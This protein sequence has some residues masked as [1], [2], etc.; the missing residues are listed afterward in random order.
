[1][2]L[3]TIVLTSA[4]LVLANSTSQ[5]IQ[6]LIFEQAFEAKTAGEGIA[7]I[8]ASCARCDWGITGHEA[9]AVRILIDAQYS[10]HLLLVRGAEDADYHMTLGPIAAGRHRVRIEADPSLS[11]KDAGPAAITSVEVT[12]VSPEGNEPLAQAM[13][14]ILYARPNTV[15]HFTD[16]PI[17]MWYEVVQT[18]HGRQ[19]RYSVIFTNEDGGTATDRL[20]AT[21]GRTTDVEYVYGAEVGAQGKVIGEEF[22]GPGHEV[23]PFRGRHE[24]AHPLIWVSTDN[25]MVSESGPTEIRYAPAPERF[26]LTNLSREAVM[27]RHPWTYTA[28]AKEMAREG[29][30]AE[31]AAPGSGRIS[32]ARHFVSV[33]ACTEL[34]NAAVAFSVHA[35]DT[36]GVARWFDS[37]RGLPAFRIVRS[38]CFRGAVPLPAG[39]RPP[40]AVR[41][42]AYTLPPRPEAPSGPG[43]VKLVRVNRVFT[44]DDRYQPNPSLF[45]WTGAGPLTLDG[46]WFELTFK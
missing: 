19:F 9:A 25:N 7:V 6:P 33:E 44:V 17:V 35:S 24:G 39:A 42:R 32:D 27:D 1:M 30:V 8:H 20:M 23:P 14:P 26:D 40:D 5:Q 13:A 36:A 41:F 4:A 10:Q 15:G 45:S 37:D 21:W 16:L 28:A 12:V 11:A 18:P 46:E 2:T 29:K 31:D 22:Q 3:R 34:T 43:A 38:G